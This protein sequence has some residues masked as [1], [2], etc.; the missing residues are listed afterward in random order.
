MLAECSKSFS[1]RNLNLEKLK[2]C[3]FFP[4]H[5]DSL[6]R[7]LQMSGALVPIVCP[8]H[9]RPLAQLHFSNVIED[10]FF[11]IS[12]C[13]DKMPMLRR[14]ETGDWIGTFAGHKG[15]V[16]SAKLN[17]GATQAAT[18]SADFTVKI[19]DALTGAEKHTQLPTLSRATHP[20]CFLPVRHGSAGTAQ[21]AEG[22]AGCR[23]TL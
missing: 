2:L 9:S 12:A 1:S 17:A 6:L 19:W 8:G 3:I 23:R 10:G 16:W 18:A 13:L 22:G 14:G 21:R 4:R 11:L 15:A 7:A 5:E 20:L